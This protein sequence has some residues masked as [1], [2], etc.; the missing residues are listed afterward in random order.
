[1]IEGSCFVKMVDVQM[2]QIRVL[3]HKDD[4]EIEDVG[5]VRGAFN[6]RSFPCT[7]LP[8]MH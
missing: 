8:I 2:H 6:D 3:H 7:Y 5:S 4:N 1:M